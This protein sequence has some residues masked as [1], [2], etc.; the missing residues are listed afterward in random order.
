MKMK[1]TLALVALL[2]AVGATTVVWSMPPKKYKP[3]LFTA[4]TGRLTK[5][6]PCGA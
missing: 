5:K 3:A 2:L 6:A 4:E 1:M